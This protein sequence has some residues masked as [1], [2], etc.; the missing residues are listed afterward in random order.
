[1]APGLAPGGINSRSTYALTW[2]GWPDSNRRPPAPKAGAL[3]KLRH[4]PWNR[5][6]AY[7]PAAAVPASAAAAE[8][9]PARRPGPPTSRLRRLRT[10]TLAVLTRYRERP[11]LTGTRGRSSMAELQPSKLVM[12]VRFPSPA[13]TRK[14]S[15]EAVPGSRLPDIRT[16]CPSFVPIACPIASW[17]CQRGVL[18]LLVRAA[19]LADAEGDMA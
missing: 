2:S 4:I 12:R 15:S 3:T 1:M 10:G 18:V 14:P 6:V 11:A 5:T 7:R 16:P 19:K 13:P 17:L 9:P 8:P